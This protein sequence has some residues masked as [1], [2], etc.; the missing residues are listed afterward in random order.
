MACTLQDEPL[1]WN[2]ENKRYHE[3]ANNKCK[4]RNT[5]PNNIAR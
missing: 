4:D 5:I 1:N 3:K 2:Q